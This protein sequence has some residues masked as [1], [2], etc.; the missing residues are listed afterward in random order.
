MF[1]SDVPF[2][3]TDPRATELQP[4]VSTYRPGWIPRWEDVVVDRTGRYVRI[5][6]PGLADGGSSK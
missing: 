3:S 5:Q 1:V 6:K 4:G 2:G